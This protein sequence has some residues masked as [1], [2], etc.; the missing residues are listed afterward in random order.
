MSMER[1][2][3][4][5]LF[6]PL[7]GG[8]WGLPG[9]FISIPGA[10][11]TDTINHVTKHTSL[12]IV[13]LSPGQHGEGAFGVTP[14]P[15]EDFLNGAK[16]TMLGYPPPWYIKSILQ[17]G[18]V[19]LDEV[20]DTPPAIQPA[21][22]GMLQA[23]MVGFYNF[24]PR[25]RV[26]AA[27]NPA[28]LGAGGGTLGAS[29]ANRMGWLPWEL[30]TNIEWGDWLISHGGCNGDDDGSVIDAE[31]EE[32]RVLAAWPSAYA[33]AAGLVAAFHR[34][35][36]GFLSKCPS[37]GDPAL[38]GP[39]PSMRTWEFATRALSSCYVHGLDR[40]DQELLVS[41]FVG[42]DARDEFFTWCDAADL[43]D[44]E[45]LLDGRIRWEH[46]KTRLDRTYA[47]LSACTALV[48]P[49]KAEHRER[50]AGALWK[51]IG[52]IDAAGGL[53]ATEPFGATLDANG[54]RTVP[55]ARE[56]LVAEREMFRTARKGAPKP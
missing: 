34:R 18:V 36:D 48:I 21:L 5:L 23:R 55:E 25:V 31:R 30:P 11:K 27:G 12:P 20:L 26:L 10:A 53:D 9:L 35:R 50:R 43:P 8:K 52:K 37:I 24:H 16:Q 28:G 4:A 49:P 1:I 19:F 38:S 17:G 40:N 44:P 2:I 14:V 42:K 45:A 41:S 47:V 7:R 56:T 33:K 15:I 46:D 51:L 54:L 39:W 32:E 22:M 13:L 29:V 6:T 3:H